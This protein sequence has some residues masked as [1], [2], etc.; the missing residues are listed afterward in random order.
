MYN[1]R[2]YISDKERMD[3]QYG[4]LVALFVKRSITHNLTESNPTKQIV[5]GGN[6]LWHKYFRMVHYGHPLS[7]VRRNLKCDLEKHDKK[8]SDMRAYI[9]KFNCSHFL[10]CTLE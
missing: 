5:E 1:P 8:S 9:K 2:N 7:F 3:D 6:L 4:D 10:F